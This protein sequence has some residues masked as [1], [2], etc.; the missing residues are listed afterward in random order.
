M[1]RQAGSAGV[2][3]CEFDRVRRHF[4]HFQLFHLQLDV[5]FDLV[6]GEHVTGQQEVHVG[7]QFSQGFAQRAADGRDVG[8]FFR[9]QVIEV[10]VHGFARMDLVGDPVEAGHQQGREAQVGVRRRVGEAGFDALCLRRLGPRNTH[11]ARPVGCGV[12]AQNGGLVA[13]DQTL[14]GVGRRVGEGV[15]RLGVLQ[16]AADEVQRLVGEVG[17]LVAR[18]ERLAVFPDR[19]VDV[20]ARTVVA[21]DRLRHERCRT[22]VGLRHVVDDV[23]VFLQLVGLFGQRGE[24]KA[25]LVLRGRHFVVVLVDL[26]AEAFHGR[27]H[28]GAD[29]LAIVGRVH[30]EVAALVGRTVAQVAH[31]EFRVGVPCGVVGVDLVGH[32]VRGDGDLDIVE[33]EELGLGAEV[34][35]VTDAG[36]LQ[37]GLGQLRGAARVAV[38]G[39]A[40]VRLDDGAV[41]A[42]RLL[43]IER[44]DVDRVRVGHQLHVGGFDRLPAG[45]GGT[46]EHEAFFEEVLV[47]QVAHHGHVLQL[48][49][50]VGEADVD[51]GNILVLDQLEN[52]SVAHSVVSFS[53]RIGFCLRGRRARGRGPVRSTGAQ[54]ASEPDSPVRMRMACSTWLTKILPSPI[55]SVLAAETMASMAPS[56]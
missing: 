22:T 23:L 15:E 1:C 35:D 6:L 14:V 46:V 10:L 54:S 4:V 52:V 20:H 36:G 55:L 38:V 41:H 5:A 24:D 51:V 33:Q 40:C 31:L 39:F 2:V 9:R 32:L 49:A 50:R 27:Q 18:E 26:H 44:V 29:V 56:T 17:V 53:V 16:D 19:H 30:R 8:Q 37:V 12:G 7:F 42:E 43:G 28:L 21:L 25:Q 47:D 48:A 3:Q 11:A 13:R 45:D 34:G